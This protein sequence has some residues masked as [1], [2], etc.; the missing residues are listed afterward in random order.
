MSSL[1]SSSP[2]L[3]PR[4]LLT[5]TGQGVLHGGVILEAPIIMQLPRKGSSPLDSSFHACGSN[6]SPLIL[7]LNHLSPVC[8]ISLHASA[9]AVVSI[10]TFVSRQRLFIPQI[11]TE[12]P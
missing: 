12:S 2:S 6:S 8:D 4:T 1:I 10:Q 5:Q 3:F 11:H 9:P 7:V